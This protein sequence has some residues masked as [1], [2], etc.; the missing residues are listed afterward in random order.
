[1]VFFGRG[2]VVVVKVTKCDFFADFLISFLKTSWKQA[3]VMAR[4]ALGS[5]NIEQGDR[6]LWGTKLYSS[7]WWGKH[8][9]TSMGSQLNQY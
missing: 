6:D 4:F 3:A 9:Y 2:T 1:L 5:N 8:K 7:Q